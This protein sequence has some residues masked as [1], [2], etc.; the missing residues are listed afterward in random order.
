RTGSARARA[1]LSGVAGPRRRATDRAG[2]ARRVLAGVVGAVALI[3]AARIPVVG[4]GRAR[5]L[6]RVRGARGARPGAVLRRVALARRRAAGGGRRLE[7]VVRTGAARPGAQLV[8]ITVARRRPTDRAG[9]AG[10]ML[11]EVARAVAGVGGAR[12]AVVRAERPAGFLHIGVA[13][14]AGQ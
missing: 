1:G 9:V 7:G 4:A 8:E 2:V 3:R 13:R 12:V 10:W 6:L 5:R 14:L 11:A